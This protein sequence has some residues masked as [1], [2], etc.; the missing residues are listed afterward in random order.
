[1]KQCSEMELSF[2]RAYVAGDCRNATEAARSAGYS[3]AATAGYRLLQRER[4]QEQIKRLLEAS[5]RQVAAIM[6]EATQNSKR[7]GTTAPIYADADADAAAALAR[8]YVIASMIESHEINLDRKPTTITRMVK[9][10]VLTAEGEKVEH[11]EGVQVEVFAR[12]ASAANKSA[13]ILLREVERM[14]GDPASR[15]DD[16]PR[17]H[18][19]AEQLEAFRRGK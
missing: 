4:V 5:R 12:D 17:D 14:E 15:A 19:L 9:R 2:A 18:Q 16:Q 8:A 11:I 3:D 1:M 10:I 6:D 7:D 13:E